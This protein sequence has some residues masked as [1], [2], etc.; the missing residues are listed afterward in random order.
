MATVEKEN[1]DPKYAILHHLCLG[2]R[3]LICLIIPRTCSPVRPPAPK[4][5]ALPKPSRPTNVPTANKP[6]AKA[7]D[8][9]K[10]DGARKIIA[11]PK[12]NPRPA[13]AKQTITSENA[14]AKGLFRTAASIVSQNVVSEEV[15][16]VAVN[17]EVTLAAAQAVQTGIIKA[18]VPEEDVD[19]GF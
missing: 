18:S 6:V 15:V 14:P 9:P 8:Q 2:A 11:L 10:T 19:M 13:I 4:A 3:S 5:I 1:I 7:P 12:S 16:A 17:E